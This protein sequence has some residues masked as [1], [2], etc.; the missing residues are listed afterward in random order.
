L[1]QQKYPARWLVTKKTSQ[2]QKHLSS[3]NQTV[4]YLQLVVLA[5]EPLD[6]PTIVPLYF[7]SKKRG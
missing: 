6:Q 4:V 2:N 7:L 3:Q 1:N 5:H